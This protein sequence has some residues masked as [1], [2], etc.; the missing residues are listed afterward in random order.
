MHARLGL[1]GLL[2]VLLG[3][4]VLLAILIGYRQPSP[5]LIQRLHL[6]DCDPPC[7]IGILPG[8]TRDTDAYQRLGEVFG[9]PAGSA[10][11]AGDPVIR[12]VYLPS[13][14]A[15][16]PSNMLPVQLLVDRG[17]VDGISI[18]AL[19]SVNSL[20]VMPALGDMVNLLGKP[21]CVDLYSAAARAWSFIYEI[22]SYVVEVGILGGDHLRWSQPISYLSLGHRTAPFQKNGC[23]SKNFNLTSWAGLASKPRYLQLASGSNS[24]QG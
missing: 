23:A 10:V 8:Q 16:N 1:I 24:N 9:A 13:I 5:A 21:T 18:P 22:D 12:L 4:C 17:M 3:G 15:E 20:D 11:V 2:S 14:Y 7:W 19:N 6:T